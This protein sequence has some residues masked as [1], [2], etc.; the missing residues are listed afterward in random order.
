MLKITAILAMIAIITSAIRLDANAKVSSEA[1]KAFTSDQIKFFENTVR[2]ARVDKTA[3][4]ASWRTWNKNTTA[5]RSE[6]NAAK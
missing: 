3:N 1:V 6:L 5:L 4:L 2:L